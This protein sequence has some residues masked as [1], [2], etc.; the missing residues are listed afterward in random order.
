M[1]LFSCLFLVVLFI[2][3]YVFKGD[4]GKYIVYVCCNKLMVVN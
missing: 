3:G 4:K 1:L 2:F